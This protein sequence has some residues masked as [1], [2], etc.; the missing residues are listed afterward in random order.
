[1]DTLRLLEVWE[2]NFKFLDTR[3]LLDYGVSN[4]NGVVA[5]AIFGDL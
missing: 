2:K 4:A 3:K 5:T 1:M